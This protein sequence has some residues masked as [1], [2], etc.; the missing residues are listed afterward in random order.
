M[1]EKNWGTGP[2]VDALRR[3]SG[4]QITAIP[5]DDDFVM[6]EKIDR[7]HTKFIQKGDPHP[8]ASALMA[9]DYDESI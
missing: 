3:D 5:E 6:R 7:L 1:M 8:W 9:L 2:A 4:E